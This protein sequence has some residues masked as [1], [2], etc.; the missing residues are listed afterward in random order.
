[1]SKLMFNVFYFVLA[2]SR[3]FNYGYQVSNIFK[4]ETEQKLHLVT[5]K[6]VTI[7][8]HHVSFVSL[9]AIDQ[10]IDIKFPSV[11][12]LEI[13]ENKFLIIEQPELVLITTVQN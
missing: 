6:T 7:P 11:S 10:P 1:M 5:T 2:T 12:L 8:S 9:K 3:C 4:N 13:E